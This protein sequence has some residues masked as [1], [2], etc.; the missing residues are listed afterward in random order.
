MTKVRHSDTLL[1]YIKGLEK[2]IATLEGQARLQ[3][4][5]ISSGKLFIRDSATGNVIA[6]LTGAAGTDRDGNPYP[7]GLTAAST[8]FVPGVSGWHIR[9]DGSAEFNNVSA[10]GTVDVGAPSTP[11]VI[12]GT[13]TFPGGGTA[14]GLIQLTD[15]GDTHWSLP[16]Y[17]A[18]TKTVNGAVE[19][20]M[21][22]L[23]P[24]VYDGDPAAGQPLD[25]VSVNITQAADGPSQ[26]QAG[27]L[28]SNKLTTSAAGTAITGAASI[29]GVLTAAN[30]ASGAVTIT[31]V[32]NT[33]TSVTVSGLSVAGSTFTGHA[34]ASTAVIGSTVQGVAVSSVTATGLLVWVYRTNTTATGVNW[35]V[36]GK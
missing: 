24:P 2:R 6:S 20:G 29:S 18:P 31:P 15:P 27:Y 13:I 16:G 11:H 3:S 25:Q 22:A 35:M 5:S 21:L 7:A 23:F 26:L 4:A 30:I 8:D 28:A 9:G 12:I 14:Q 32:A 36:I 34:T 33:P 10:R 1:S 19:N 17:L